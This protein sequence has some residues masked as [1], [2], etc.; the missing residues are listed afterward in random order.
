MALK[1]NQKENRP[2][3]VVQPEERQTHQFKKNTQKGP[4]LPGRKAP[5][6]QLVGLFGVS[7][8]PGLFKALTSSRGERPNGFKPP[9]QWCLVLLQIP[10]KGSARNLGSGALVSSWSY[11]AN[12]LKHPCGRSNGC[13]LLSTL[14]SFRSSQSKS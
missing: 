7:I 3:W 12:R 1:G 10:K 4:F 11:D 14:C 5:L 13:G 6:Q 8:G 9:P 2:F